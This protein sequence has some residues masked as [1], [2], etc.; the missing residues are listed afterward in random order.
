VS[1]GISRINGL[2]FGGWVFPGDVIE[3]VEVSI[4]SSEF[5]GTTYFDQQVNFT[6]SNCGGNSYGYNVCDETGGFNGPT[7]GN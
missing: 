7:L 2:V 5:G 1:Q 3:S 6:G 4:T